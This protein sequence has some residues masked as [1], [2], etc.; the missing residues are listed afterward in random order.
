MRWISSIVFIRPMQRHTHGWYD[1][2][3]EITTTTCKPCLRCGGTRFIMVSARSVSYGEVQLTDADNRTYDAYHEDDTVLNEDTE[4]PNDFARYGIF[5]NPSSLGID[6]DIDICVG[7]GTATGALCG[8]DLIAL[9]A[10]SDDLTGEK[11]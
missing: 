8:G 9:P 7:C 11:P 6:I 10:T 4:L 5:N 1:L 2:T 3:M